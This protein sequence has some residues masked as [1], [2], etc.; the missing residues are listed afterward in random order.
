MIGLGTGTSRQLCQRCS[1]QISRTSPNRR[2]HTAGFEHQYQRQGQAAYMGVSR[3]KRA[4]IHISGMGCRLRDVHRRRILSSNCVISP[5]G[6]EVGGN[7][8]FYGTTRSVGSVV[9][10]SLKVALNEPPGP[11]LIIS[12]KRQKQLC[13]GLVHSDSGFRDS[14][15]QSSLPLQALGLPISILGFRILEAAPRLANTM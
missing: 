13:I 3:S 6:S 15:Y 14:R 11:Q 5:S 2:Q 9:L 1:D 8:W 7:S 4:V 10:T 12:V